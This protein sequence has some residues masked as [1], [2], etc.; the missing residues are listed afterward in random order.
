LNWE[1]RAGASDATIRRLEHELA[2]YLL[3]VGEIPPAAALNPVPG[4]AKSLEARTPKDRLGRSF[5]QLDAN[6]RLMRYPCS[7]MIYSE[8]FDAL[9][10]TIKQ[11]VYARM[12]D[13]L[14]SD[15]PRALGTVR[16]T[17]DDRRAVLE[18]LRETKPDFPN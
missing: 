12:V 18:I 14:G 6:N 11:A 5:G 17:A 13:V 1:P 7:Y 3:F 16:V 2:D 4:F 15:V 8:A 9:P 10:P